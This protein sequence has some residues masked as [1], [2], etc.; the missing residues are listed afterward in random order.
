MEICI[1]GTPTEGDDLARRVDP[2]VDDRDLWYSL[3]L[4]AETEGNE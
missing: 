1:T 4:R 2:P 3:S